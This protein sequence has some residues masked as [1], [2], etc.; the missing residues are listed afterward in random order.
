M[1]INCC[2][3]QLELIGNRFVPNIC[4]LVVSTGFFSSLFLYTK[5]KRVG[6]I[7]SYQKQS[8]RLSII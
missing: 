1:N 7:D 2:T 4:K 3:S 8:T 6:G 5:K